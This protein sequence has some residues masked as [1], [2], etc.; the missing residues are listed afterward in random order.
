MSHRLTGQRS[1]PGCGHSTPTDDSRRGPA[2]ASR[3]P[4]GYRRLRVINNEA[5]N[6]DGEFARRAHGMHYLFIAMILSGFWLILSGHYEPLLLALGAVSVALVML[7]LRRMDDADH[8]PGELYPTAALFGYFVWLMGCVIRSNIDLARRIWHP[9]LPIQ[10]SWTR[11]DTKVTT[12]MEKT[13]Y[14][15]SITLTPGTLTTDVRDDHFMVHSLSQGSI[16]ELREGEME[17]RIRRLGI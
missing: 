13:L 15:N 1:T 10:L 9:S 16:D 2:I 4:F 8:E 6:P 11:L 3:Y 12:P 5:A 17:R 7:L 14:A